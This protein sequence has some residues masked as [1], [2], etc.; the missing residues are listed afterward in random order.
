MRVTLLPDWL[1]LRKR[2]RTQ[3]LRSLVGL[4]VVRLEAEPLDQ[5]WT[6]YVP[7]EVPPASSYMGV[8]VGIGGTRFL[9]VSSAATR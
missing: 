7:D 8:N 2:E 6:S 5:L 9:S 1:P 4:H 3:G